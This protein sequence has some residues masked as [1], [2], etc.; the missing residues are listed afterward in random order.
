MDLK[1]ALK[2]VLADDEPMARARLSRLLS[3]AGCEV[4]AEFGEGS[5]LLDYLAQRPR[6][7]ALFLDIQMPGPSGLEV[8]AELP[9]PLPVVF[10]TAFRE[11]SLDAFE[12]DAADYLLKPVRAERL[13]RTLDRLREGLIQPQGGSREATQVPQRVVIRAGEGLIFLDL[14]KVTHFEVEEGAVWAWSGSQ[15][16]ATQWKT[17][18]E[19]EESFPEALLFRIQRHLLV[20]PE[21]ITGL[22]PLPGNRAM[23]RIG[24][25]ELEVSRTATALLKQT[26]GIKGEF[27][28][29]E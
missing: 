16:F 10:V 24:E 11:H 2:V 7:D 21:C 22:R 6:L 26:L 29:R 12:L 19:V 8:A 14:R 17:L 15:R 4:V 13:A 27:G 9:F 20:R 1:A 18:H 28:K 3:E 5:T 23:A 25:Q